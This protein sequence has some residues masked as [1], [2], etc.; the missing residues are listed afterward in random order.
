MKRN[1]LLFIV[2]IISLVAS[3]KVYMQDRISFNIYLGNINLSLLSKTE[4]DT[5][6]RTNLESRTQERVEFRLDKQPLDIDLSKAHVQIDYSEMINEAGSINQLQTIL[7]RY[8]LSPKITFDLSSQIKELAKQAEQPAQDATIWLDEKNN[9]TY[10][11]AADGTKLDELELKR[12]IDSFIVTGSYDNTLPTIKTEP[13]FTSEEALLAKAALE[14]IKTKPI[15]LIFEDQKFTIDVPT[16]FFLLNLDRN[17]KPLPAHTLLDPV[18][19]NNFLRNIANSINIPVEEPLFKFNSGNK[20]VSEFRPAQAGRELEIDKTIELING[21]FTTDK[22]DVELPV[23]ITEPKIQTSEINKLGI[24]ELLA[25]GVSHFAGSIPNRIYNVGLT[26]ARINGVLI[27][28]GETFSFLKTV[29][30]INAETGFKQAYVI[31]EGRTVLDDGGGVCQVSTTLFRAALNSGLPIVART[32]HAYRVGYYEQGFPPGLD[33]T[34]FYPS[35]DFKFK[36]DT[37]SHILIQ[38]Y[39]QGTTLYIDLYGT[40]D[41]RVAS[42]T[43]PVVT[44]QTPPPPE[45]RQDDPSL[46]RGQIKQVD[47]AAWGAR[48][49]FKRTVTKNGETIANETWRSNYRP[50]QAVYLVGTQ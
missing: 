48:V 42:L 46:P 50:W 17:L 33:A 15:T 10:K 26:A 18:K 13:N 20:R 31:K 49:S 12:Q 27:A 28:P 16:L 41:G 1:L 4:A 24:N 36:N 11:P 21:S 7:Q 37:G 22:K 43:T 3:Y 14:S 47:W 2:L 8:E 38:A 29:G 6:L 40:P 19:L 39:T 34:V 45:L 5:L 9:I 32:A 25:S 44:D 23:R 35:V 30:E